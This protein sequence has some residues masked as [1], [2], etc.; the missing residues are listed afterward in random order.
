MFR[1]SWLFGAM[2]IGTTVVPYVLS[3]S[4]GV[5][6]WI[7]SKIPARGQSE[8]NVGPVAATTT[9]V[10]STTPGLPAGT[11]TKT[12]A[13]RA[14][15]VPT[16]PLEEV[17]Q[18]DVTTSWIQTEWP[19]VSAD[20]AELDMHGYRVPLVSGTTDSD[21]AGSLTYYFNAQQQVARITFF[22]STGD[23]RRLIA[24]LES[25]FQFQHMQTKEPNVY[26]WQVSS[27]GKVSS[28][29]RIR[30]AKI[31]RSSSPHSRYEI[32]MVIERPKSAK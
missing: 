1:R 6:Q 7:V 10:A 19:R 21:V 22:G 15:D 13:A 3:T 25:R 24:L 30:P 29:M 23:P 17:L 2:I 31:L 16:H 11:V 26:L 28:E 14:E 5:K 18:F 4:S 12:R 9:T 20:L 32:A 27:W 8:A